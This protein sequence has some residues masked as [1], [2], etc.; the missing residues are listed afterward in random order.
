M[1][2]PAQC[3]K[4]SGQSWSGCGAHAEQV[5]SQVPADKQCTCPKESGKTVPPGVPMKR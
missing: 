4:C 5:M 3:P 2:F 1:C